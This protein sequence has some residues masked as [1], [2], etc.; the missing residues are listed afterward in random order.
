M[1]T[2]PRDV[3]HQGGICDTEPLKAVHAA[4][5]IHGT[6]IAYQPHVCGPHGWT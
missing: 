4:A 6:G 2:G 1:L 3:R 5:L